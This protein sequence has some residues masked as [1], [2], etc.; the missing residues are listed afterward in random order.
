MRSLL[1]ALMIACLMAESS[2]ELLDGTG[3]ARTCAVEEPAPSPTTDADRLEYCDCP[4][5]ELAPA[6]H[7]L[8]L[9]FFAR[10]I[11]Q[12][13]RFHPNSVGPMT[14]SGH[15]AQ[16]IAQFMPFTWRSAG[17]ARPP[18]YEL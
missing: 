9:E 10:L 8:P 15:R 7:G 12:E 6:A 5:L 17:V 4:I 14:R 1:P 13:S 3:V 11:W 2:A 18:R 16:G